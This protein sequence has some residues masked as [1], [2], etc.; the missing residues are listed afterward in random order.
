[1][2]PAAGA[3]IVALGEDLLREVFIHLPASAD[4]L[5]AAAACKPFLRAACSAP[6]LL[7]FEVWAATPPA[8]ASSAASSSSPTAASANPTSYPSLLPLPPPRRPLR[9][10]PPTVAT[11]PS[12]SFPA[13]VGWAR[14]QPR[15]STWT[16]ATAAFSSRTWGPMNSPSRI[17]SPAATSPS[18]AG[19][20]VGYG[21]FTDDGDSSEFRVVCVSRDAASPELRALV[22]ASGEL[23]WADVAGIACQ[24]DLAAGSRVMQ[25]NRSLYWRLKGGERMVAFST[26]SMELSVLDLPPALRDLRFDAFDRGEED[27]ANVLHLLTMTGYRLEVWAGTADGDG[28]MAWRQVEKSLRFHKALTVMIDPSLESYERI[29]PSVQS[30]R[31]DVDVIGVASGL[32]FFRKWTNIFSIDLETMKLKMLPKA[33]CLGALIYPYTIAWPPSFLN[34]AGQGG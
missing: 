27:D 13:A 23:S 22:L 16:A 26:A 1:M 25:A 20:A 24:P 3:P 15:G 33:D 19:R 5:R 2:A 21:L 10:R 4:L 9:P 17:P 30:Y 32:V 6:F 29:N 14:A 28:G 34:P 7:R 18:P 12:P 8:R 31:D 11:S